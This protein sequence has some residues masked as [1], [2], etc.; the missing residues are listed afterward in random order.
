MEQEN[1]KYKIVLKRDACI[2]AR[3][4][5]ALDPELWEDTPDGKVSIKGGTK[6]LDENGE[7]KE[8]YII[9]DE[10]KDVRMDGAMSCP[11]LVIHVYKIK[12]G[13]ETMIYPK[14]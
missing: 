11:V 4:C 12:D 7:I 1:V 13:V 9:L 10:L 3:G 6:I 2:G 5:S 14:E 8:E